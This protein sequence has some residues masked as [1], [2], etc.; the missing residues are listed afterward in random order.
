MW[1][2]VEL[3]RAAGR[4]AGPE[5]H[6]KG[7]RKSVLFLNMFVFYFSRYNSDWLCGHYVKGPNV[8]NIIFHKH[9]AV[10]T[11]DSTEH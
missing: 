9:S 5:A 11:R 1:R 3:F 6:D 4:L 7:K 10:R 2:G 8:H